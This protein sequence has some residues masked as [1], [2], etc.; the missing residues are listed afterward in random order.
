MKKMKIKKLI[1]DNFKNLGAI[2][3]VVNRTK[4]DLGYGTFAMMLFLCIER[5]LEWYWFLILPLYI[6]FKIKDIDKYHGQEAEYNFKKNPP[7][8]RLYKMIEQNNKMLK[9][10]YTYLKGKEWNN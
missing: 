4:A 10:I 3:A 2:K 1:E 5:G 8:K 7:M 9:E 6:L